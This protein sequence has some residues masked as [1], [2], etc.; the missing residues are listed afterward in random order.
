[1]IP[2]A[3]SPNQDGMNDYFI[4]VTDLGQTIISFIVYNRFGNAVY[5]HTKGS[6]GWD[7]KHNGGQDAD[8]GAYIYM[9][10]YECSDNKVYSRRGDVVLIR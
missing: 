10:I 7:G 6:H 2:T 9:M 4:P 8:I 5:Q 3:F 1:M